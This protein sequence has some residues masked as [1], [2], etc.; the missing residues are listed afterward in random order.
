MVGGFVTEDLRRAR[1][2]VGDWAGAISD[3]DPMWLSSTASRDGFL[4]AMTIDVRCMKNAV[5]FRKYILSEN[6]IQ[7]PVFEQ[8]LSKPLTH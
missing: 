4:L 2:E 1:R 6:Y 5:I 3:S 7:F 8:H